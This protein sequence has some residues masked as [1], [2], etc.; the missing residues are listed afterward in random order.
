MSTA[1]W[2]DHYS[3]GVAAL[4][5]FAAVIAA[6]GLLEG[7]AQMWTIV[8]IAAV[9]EAMVVLKGNGPKPT[10]LPATPDDDPAAL[11]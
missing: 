4:L 7:A 2:V 6:S 10:E 11:G 5:A 1:K 9:G 8:L 3:K